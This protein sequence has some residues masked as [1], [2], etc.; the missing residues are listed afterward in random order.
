MSNSIRRFSAAILFF[1]LIVVSG[2]AT[3]KYVRHE[4]GTVEP[5][6]TEVRDAQAQQA[7]RID[8]VDRRA[9]EGLSA[10]NRAAMAADT[11]NERAVAAER[12]V[13][14][15]DR[16]VDTM[17][18]NA[19]RAFNRIETAESRLE[20][21]IDNVDKYSV[22]DQ[23]TVTFKFDSDELTKEAIS[24]LDDIAGSIS[25][26]QTGYLIEVQG[27]TDNIGTE[28]YNFRLSMRRAESVMRYLV[29]KNVPL[30]R[31]SFVGLGKT[32][33]VA[34]NETPKGRE[35]NRRVEIRLL[36][37]SGTVATANR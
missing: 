21:R 29:G 7:E 9:Q 23:K 15:V 5:Q 26:G 19:R 18:Q 11:A 27:F 8:A 3:R 20:N 10:A 32:N 2:C 22:A 37:S 31:I 36:R 24:T 4:V 16:R 1:A 34:D 6:I 17:Q 35:Q 25:E 13:T 12:H 14:E 30:H 28:K 33:A